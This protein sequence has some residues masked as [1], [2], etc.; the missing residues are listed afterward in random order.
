MAQ[1][2]IKTDKINTLIE[3]I[4]VKFF[5]RFSKQLKS[6]RTIKLQDIPSDRVLEVVS[7]N[8][9]LNAVIIAFLVGALTTV[10]A[11]L[12]EIYYSEV[13]EP[14]YYYGILSLITIL[15]L[16][17][18][19]GV[20]YWLGIRMVYTLAYLTGYKE[21]EES[22]LPPEYDVKK[23]MVRSALEIEDPAIEYLGIDPQKYVSA[24]WLFMRTLLYKAKIMLTTVLAKLILRKVAMRYGV[25]VG[26]VWVAIPV[27]AIW[28]AIVMYRVVKDAKL[29]L[30]G[31]HLSKY[32]AR[33]IITDNLLDGY[34]KEIR[35]GAIRAVSTIMILS[36]NY[37]P[38]NVLLLIRLNENLA[39]KEENG[40]DDLEVYL[41][42][43]EKLTLEEKHLLR[44]LSGMAAVFDGKMKREEEEA[45]VKI[46]AE[47]GERY[48]LFTQELK[49]LLLA[50]H[51]HQAAHLC[52]EM[53]LR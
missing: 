17:I 40:Y 13:L 53:I 6:E 45:L 19:V 15:F 23:I 39:I 20:L 25:R 26:F 21:H 2:K 11:V 9:T 34:S 31:Y 37:H 52:E 47:E 24:Y 33:E 48:M 8:I 51:I 46:F 3:S 36:Q 29:R 28:D 43:L 1:P 4:G 41:A 42:Y 7:Q 10:P 12:F 50:G 35:E 38:N 18:E 49:T 27:T 14:L 30:F 22:T 5:L 16:V 44:T 32:I